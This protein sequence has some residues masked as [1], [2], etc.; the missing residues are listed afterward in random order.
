MLPQRGE[1]EKKHKIRNL[2]NN[3]ITM[4]TCVKNSLAIICIFFLYTVIVRIV[5]DQ[6]IESIYE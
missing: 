4:N 1:F 5:Q 2:T 6:Y 3:Y